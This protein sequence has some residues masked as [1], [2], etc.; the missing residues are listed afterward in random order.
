M[1][2]I[3]H[4]GTHKTGSTSFQKYV[5]HD[6]DRLA[7]AGIAVYDSFERPTN[8]IELYLGTLD[9]RVET[10]GRQRLD[11][12]YGPDYAARVKD[13]IARQMAAAPGETMLFTT[14]GLSLLRTPEEC[15]HLRGLFPDDVTRFDIV[16]VL[17]D[18]P[19]FLASYRTQL[20]KRPGRQPSADPRSALYVEDDTWLI[21]YDRMIQAYLSVF[22]SLRLVGYSR[23]GLLERLCDAIGL[24]APE[25]DFAFNRS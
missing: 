25:A 11:G 17:R 18:K 19:G 12:R 16:C 8:H 9:P 7:R 3:L 23:D 15:R 13:S 2:V 6:R 14:E 10:F 22:D 4:I 5:H 20:L 21:D 24:P 1:K